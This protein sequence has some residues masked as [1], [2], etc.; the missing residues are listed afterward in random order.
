MLYVFGSVNLS[1]GKFCYEFKGVCRLVIIL[2]VVF[3]VKYIVISIRIWS[4]YLR[5]ILFDVVR[6]F[7][8]IVEF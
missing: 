1:L 3:C 7:G 6:G 8:D 2:D 4:L 5:M